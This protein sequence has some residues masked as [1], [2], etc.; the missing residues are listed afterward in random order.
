[1]SVY[2]L[3]LFLILLIFLSILDLTL[4]CLLDISSILGSSPALFHSCKIALVCLYPLLFFW[5]FH[6]QFFTLHKTTKIFIGIVLAC[7]LFMNMV[8]LSIYLTLL[9]CDF[10]L[11]ILLVL[12][13]CRWRTHGWA[14]LENSLRAE[15]RSEDKEVFVNSRKNQYYL[16][17]Q[18]PSTQ[19]PFILSIY[20]SN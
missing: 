6:N 18:H 9:F 1:M 20:F 4:Y 2:N 3:I 11:L 7:I 15:R 16:G 5:K 19:G 17:I 14:R 10:N 8:H 13:L 12:I